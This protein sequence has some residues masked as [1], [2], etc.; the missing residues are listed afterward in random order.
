MMEEKHQESR[1][2]RISMHSLKNL[3]GNST[4]TSLFSNHDKEFSAKYGIELFN[5]IDRFGFELSD[6]QTKIMEGLLRGFSETGYK[7]NITPKRRDEIFKEKYDGK[8]PEAYKYIYEI[9]RLRAT[10]SQILE[11]AGINKNSIASKTRALEALRELGTTQFCFYYERLAFAEDGQPHKDREGKWKKENVSTVDM[12]FTIKEV[13]EKNNTLSYYEI[14]PSSIFLDQIEGFFL[15]IPYKWRE[16]V[17]KL[18]GNKKASAYTF[19]FLLFLRYQHELKRRSKNDEM[20]NSLKWDPEEIAIAIKMPESIYKRQKKRMNEILEDAY[21][22]AKHLGYLSDYERK[23]HLDVL[24][25]NENKYNLHSNALQNDEIIYEEEASEITDM[26][27]KLCNYFVSMRKKLDP[28]F[29]ISAPSEKSAYISDFKELLEK[30]PQ[31]DIEA[32]I[33][34]SITQQYWSSQLSTPSK[35]RKL[36]SS[37][38]GEYILSRKITKEDLFEKNKQLS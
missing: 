13:S 34:W 26:A 21:Q 30:R 17:R 29:E 20:R 25:F 38:W 10:Q 7:G 4:Q 5:S 14:T 3:L 11:W 16:E 15:L 2:T 32:L 22:V 9:P 31:Q 18:F 36:F 19:R 12:L 23:G 35:I 1:L 33:T 6:I 27:F 28:H 8:M 24:T 37:A